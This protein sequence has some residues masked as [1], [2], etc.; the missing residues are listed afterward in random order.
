ML[1]SICLGGPLSTA[2][3]E[4]AILFYAGRYKVMGDLLYPP[5]LPQG[6]K[7]FAARVSKSVGVPAEYVLFPREKHGFTERAHQV[8]TTRRLLAWFEQ[9]LKP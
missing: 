1:A 9:Y 6:F 4:Y 8:E 5:A 2:T 7:D 3:R